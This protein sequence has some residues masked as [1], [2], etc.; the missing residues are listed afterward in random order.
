MN[1]RY[2]DKNHGGTLIVWDR[3]FGTF[4]QEDAAD[5]PVYGL[6]K[7]IGTYNPFRIAFHEWAEMVRDVAAAKNWRERWKY[8]MGRPGWKY[9]RVV[10]DTQTLA[11]GGD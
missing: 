10:A 5:P 9:E 7:N 2:L 1:R 6:T 8:V 11:V 4:A 3:L